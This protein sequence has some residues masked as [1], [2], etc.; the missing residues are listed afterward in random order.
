MLGFR[1]QDVWSVVRGVG[2]KFGM[3]DAAWWIAVLAALLIEK[4]DKRT[5]TGP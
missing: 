2:S 5:G 1:V 3:V 4:Y